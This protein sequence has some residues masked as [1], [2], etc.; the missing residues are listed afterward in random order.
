MRLPVWQ[1][2]VPSIIEETL[3]LSL[4]KQHLLWLDEGPRA[5]RFLAEGVSLRRFLM[6]RSSDGSRDNGIR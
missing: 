5:K 1:W 6:C 4:E 2:P 3:E